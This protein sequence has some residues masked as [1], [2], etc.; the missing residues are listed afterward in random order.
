MKKCPCCNRT[1][2][3]PIRWWH[4]DTMY[5]EDSLNYSLCCIHC[6]REDDYHM[7]WDWQEYYSSQGYGG[8]WPYEERSAKDYHSSWKGGID[9]PI[10]HLGE[11]N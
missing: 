4:R 7:Y 1:R 2:V 8:R 11:M 10:Q 5:H 6:I 9:K 3:G